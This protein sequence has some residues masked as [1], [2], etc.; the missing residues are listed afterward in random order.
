MINRL[1]HQKYYILNKNEL[2]R[3][4]SRL[5]LSCPYS[6]PDGICSRHEIIKCENGAVPNGMPFIPDFIKVGQL[7]HHHNQLRGLGD[8]DGRTGSRAGGRTHAHANTYTSR[9]PNKE[10]RS[11]GTL[12]I[13]KHFK[14]C[15]W[16]WTNHTASTLEN[17]AFK[18]VWK[19]TVLGCIKIYLTLRKTT[20]CQ[21]CQFRRRDSN[22]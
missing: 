7:V 1:W 12:T 18:Q 20:K 11:S 4:M 13:V 8:G 15:G 6:Y 10:Q 2:L 22:P 3:K 9:I 19:E 5:S 21:D 16:L 17:G 14:K